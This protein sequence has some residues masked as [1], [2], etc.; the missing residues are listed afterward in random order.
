LPVSSEGRLQVGPTLQSVADP[1]VFAVGDC[2]VMEGSPRPA[3]GVFGVR[4]APILLHNLAA[5]GG[6]TMFRWW[7]V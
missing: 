6:A 2:S 5:L 1:T 4:A 3:A 7:H